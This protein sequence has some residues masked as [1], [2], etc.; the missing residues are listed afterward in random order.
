MAEQGRARVYAMRREVRSC[1]GRAD[2]RGQDS[3]PVAD[4]GE[5]LAAALCLRWFMGFCCVVVAAMSFTDVQTI[6]DPSQWAV[7]YHRHASVVHVVH[8]ILVKWRGQKLAL[9][10]PR[11]QMIF[12][13]DQGA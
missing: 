5:G 13:K 9:S 2:G 11:A 12:Q 1:G 7:P 4:M 8:E 10:R 6:A 3:Q